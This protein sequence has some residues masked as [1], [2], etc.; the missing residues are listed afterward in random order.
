MIKQIGAYI[1]H[2]LKVLRDVR[3]FFD[4]K[5]SIKVWT[6]DVKPN[7]LQTNMIWFTEQETYY[8]GDYFITGVFVYILY[9]NNK[10]FHMK[11][12][13]WKMNITKTIK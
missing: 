1:K 10:A 3:H 12:D 2:Q 8:G 11:I 4:F 5:P 6:S 9:G 13:W 7:H